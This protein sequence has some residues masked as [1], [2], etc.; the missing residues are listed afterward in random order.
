M[1]AVLDVRALAV[2]RVVSTDALAIGFFYFVQQ[3]LHQ[4]GAGA[5]NRN[6]R[7]TRITLKSHDVQI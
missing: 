7:V 6:T 2:P 5:L 4:S 1:S 3:Q